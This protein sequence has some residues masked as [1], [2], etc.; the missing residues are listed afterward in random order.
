MEDYGG[1]TPIEPQINGTDVPP[2]YRS[3][4]TV[5][6]DFQENSLYN[7]LGINALKVTAAHEFHHA[8]Q[9]GSYGYWQ[10]DLYAYELTSTWLEDVVY[11]DVNDYYYYLSSY[12][13][14]F[15]SGLSFNSNSYGGYERSIFAHCLAKKYGADI[16]KDIWT[17]MKVHPFLESTDAA[18]INR[19]SNLQ[20][21]FAEYTMWNY[22][23]WDS[24]DTVNYY[25]E[26]NHYPR[27]KPLQKI[28]FY[29]TTS[30]ASGNVQ[31]LSSSM[32]EF[33][34]Q[35]DTLTAV[36]ANSDAGGAI[37]RN[38]TPQKIDITL[39]SQSLSSP[40]QEFTNGLK[41]KISVDTLSL[42]RSYFMQSSTHT[43]VA[44]LQSDASPNPF[45]LAE[46]QILFLPIN[47]DKAPFADV[48]IYTSDFSLAY[49]G[50]LRTS[51][52]ENGSTRVIE[53]PASAV[54][55]KLSSGVYFIL[56]KTAN[57]QYKWK[58][59]VIR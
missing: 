57:S 27:F 4:I 47:E 36:I 33:D 12:F 7:T 26:G 29:N 54:Q 14:G 11:T 55:L 16:M 21:A 43:V 35:H 34:M 53:V 31:P 22:Y 18:L 46:A 51:Y 6:N 42:W 45:R 13:D 8:I 52:N 20:T 9:I 49:S 24:A 56:A 44:R 3:F 30:T 58:V 19:G 1:T 17:G 15:S 32:Y 25:P 59:A 39:S 48:C 5:D 41:A 10:Y 38:T 50:Q 28:D 2:R 23:T 40:Y 37:L